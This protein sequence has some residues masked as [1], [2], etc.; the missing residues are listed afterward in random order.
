MTTSEIKCMGT[1]PWTEAY[2]LQLPVKN[3]NQVRAICSQ[4]VGKYQKSNLYYE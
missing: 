2:R 1:I 4:N 3:T